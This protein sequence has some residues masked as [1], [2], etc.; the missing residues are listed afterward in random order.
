MFTRRKGVFTVL[1]CLVLAVALV[2]VGCGGSEPTPPAVEEDGKAAWPGSLTIGAA[3]IGGTYYLYAGGWSQVIE[4]ATGIS[5]AV[6]VTGGPNDNMQLVH[7]ND[8]DLGMVTM[9]PAWEGWHGEGDW[10]G[11]VKM[12]N[13]RAIFPMYN[14]YS[15]W[16]A[17]K[18]AGINSLNDLEGKSLGVGP[19]GGTPG[20][21]HPRILELL[22]INATIRW[23]GLSDLVSQHLDLQL[24]ANSFAAGIPVAGILETAAQ[25]DI[26]LFGVDG[27]ARD[28]VCA[29]WP[30][31][32]PAVIP[33]DVYDFL[34]E[35]V[36]T[37]GIWNVA[38]A[39]KDLPEDLVY[40]IVKAVF[41][42][43]DMM[44]TAH[45]SAEETV[46]ENVV[47]NNWLPMHPG[48]IK[49]YEEIGIELPAEVYPP[50]YQG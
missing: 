12:T 3:S 17:F 39:H 19:A 24:N 14:T 26:V 45:K 7:L 48:A 16:W 31:W 4:K 37:I 29:E 8:L 1:L 5:T 21:Y 30:F 25:R 6:E 41:D 10:T 18:N 42:N 27:E 44:V 38:I 9:G 43:H 32:S 49:Y 20:T 33:A 11:G 36:E 28:K 35:D 23:A 50:E 46:A 13:V 2:A 15:Q 34:E 47:K 40:E 22:G